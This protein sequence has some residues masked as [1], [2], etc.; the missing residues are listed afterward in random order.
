MRTRTA[1]HPAGRKPALGL[2]HLLTFGLAITAI[3][4]LFLLLLLGMRF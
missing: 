1:E 3:H 2:P 4:V